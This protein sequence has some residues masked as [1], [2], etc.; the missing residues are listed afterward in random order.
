MLI[1][2]RNGNNEIVDKKYFDDFIK[3]LNSKVI[4]D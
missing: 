4:I 2:L 1:T 3:K